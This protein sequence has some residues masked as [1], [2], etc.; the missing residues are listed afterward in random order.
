LT[1]ART[2]R[3]QFRSLV[4][5]Q[6]VSSLPSQLQ[7]LASPAAITSATTPCYPILIELWYLF[8]GQSAL[9][10]NLNEVITGYSGYSS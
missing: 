7:S 1:S 8:S 9:L 10:T 3:N 5:S 2:A 6:L 4:F